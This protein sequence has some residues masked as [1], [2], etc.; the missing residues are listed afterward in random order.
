MNSVVSLLLYYTIIPWCCICFHSPTNQAVG[1][2]LHLVKFYLQ[3]CRYNGVC[4]LIFVPHC[5][6]TFFIY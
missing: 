3:S 4:G 1:E 5:N 6:S 2:K